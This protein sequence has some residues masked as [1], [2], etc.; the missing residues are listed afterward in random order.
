MALYEYVC[1]NHGPF[2][3]RARFVE[4][5]GKPSRCPVCGAPSKRKIGT[6]ATWRYK[7]GSVPHGGRVHQDG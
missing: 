5:D 2:E 3:R 6:L 7:G 1:S 4:R